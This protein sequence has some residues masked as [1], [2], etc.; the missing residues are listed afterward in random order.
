MRSLSHDMKSPLSTLSLAED[1]LGHN[2]D[3]PQ[4]V[5]RVCLLIASVHSLAVIL[6]ISQ[7]PVPAVSAEHPSRTTD[8]GP[9][10][11]CCVD[12]GAATG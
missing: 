12:L 6:P 10:I 8:Y 7:L 5:Q 1:M 4:S 3:L 11:Y 2:Q 9:T